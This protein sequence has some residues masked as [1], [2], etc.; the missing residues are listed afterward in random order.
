MT[1]YYAAQRTFWVDPVSGTIVKATGARL[2]LLRPR[3]SQTRGDVRRLQGHDERTDHRGAGRPMPATRVTSSHCGAESCRSRSPPSAWSPW[4]AAFLLG[5]FT[6]RAEAALIDP[7][8]DDASHGFFGRR[9]DGYRA[10]AR[11]RSRDREDSH[12]ATVGPTSGPTGLIAPAR[13]RFP[14]RNVPALR[15]LA[16][17]AYALALSLA[18][19][20]PLLAPGY[21]LIRDAVSTPR[22]YLTDAALGLTEAAPRA[23]PQ[24]FAVALASRVIDGGIVVKLLLLVGLWVAGWGAARGWRRHSSRRSGRPTRRRDARGVESLCRRTTAARPLEPIGRLRLPALG[25][26]G[27]SCDCATPTALVAR[28]CSGS[29]LPG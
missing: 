2:P 19:T 13:F 11:R 27:R 3:R 1:R 12:A 15:R 10:H 9:P 17:P 29:R 21:L 24:D 28:C 7:G 14:G 26:G 23:L 4:W 16:V 8:L 5:S 22:A 6:L 25:G 20:A 18:V